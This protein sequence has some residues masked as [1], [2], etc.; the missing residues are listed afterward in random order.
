MIATWPFGKLAVDAAAEKVAEGGSGLDGIE[1]GIRL[2]ET[3][4]SDGS[5]G[6]AGRPNAAGRPTVL[7]INTNP[8]LA[9]DAGFAATAAEAG[10]TYDDM[11]ARILRA[12][13][14]QSA[15]VA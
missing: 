12:A 3:L 2:I 8:C 15:K 7:E 6:L 14:T 10:M 11:I 4:G 5:V 13:W 9:A 1:E